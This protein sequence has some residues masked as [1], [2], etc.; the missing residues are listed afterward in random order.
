MLGLKRTEHFQRIRNEV[1]RQIDLRAVV[2]H[3]LGLT[4]RGK[5][6]QALCPFHHEHTPS[7]T[8]WEDHFFCFGCEVIGNI[9]DWLESSEGGCYDPKAAY[10]QALYLAGIRPDRPQY[11]ERSRAEPTAYPKPKTA[12]AS[13]WMK[14]IMEQSH[15]ALARQNGKVARAAYHYLVKRGLESVIDVV[16]FGVVEYELIE[17][18]IA[19]EAPKRIWSW[20]GRIVIPFRIDDQ[21]VW[22][23]LRYTGTEPKSL[24]KEKNILRYDGPEVGKDVLPAPFNAG[25]LKYQGE[26]VL[27]EGE[28]NAAALMVAIG[29]THP[30]IGL[31]GG[32]LPL[33]WEEHLKGRN[34]AVI[35][36][37]DSAGHH[38]RS[39]LMDLFSGYGIQART[40]SITSGDEQNL[41]ANDLLMAHGAAD[42]KTRLEEV[43]K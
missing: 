3:D 21:A 32:R 24:L 30:I 37:N 38:H 40:I 17:Q 16:G 29:A 9:F 14:P 41:D 13:A 28:L 34:C 1:I 23:K 35:A 7:F 22:F 12:V 10:R 27:I 36:D 31:P 8:V 25:S 18:S 39:S 2:A 11:F 20:C 6:L 15:R 42:L 19:L 26:V 33:G 43:L 5:T 4:P